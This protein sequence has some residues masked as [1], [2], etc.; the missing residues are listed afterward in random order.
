VL[1]SVASGWL[2]RDAYQGGL[3]TAALGA[4]THY[5]IAFVVVAVY[6]AA[7]SRLPALAR[8]PFVYGPLYGVLV[9]LVMSRVVVPM[10]P[11]AVG[12]RTL[13]GVING[14]FIH[15][16]GIGLPAALFA[17]R[18]WGPGGPAHADGPVWRGEPSPADA[19]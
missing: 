17:R 3:A 10:S 16:L 14:L 18:T 13:A 11:A 12:P 19:L 8:S 7:S 9:Y 6:L 15:A 1:Q 2:G 5:F 4:V